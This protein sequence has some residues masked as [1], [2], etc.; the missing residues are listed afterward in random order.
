MLDILTSIQYKMKYPM[1]VKV[2][3]NK[4][5]PWKSH[6]KHHGN[7]DIHDYS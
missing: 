7:S 3:H 4:L 6:I 5:N 2:K 1:Q